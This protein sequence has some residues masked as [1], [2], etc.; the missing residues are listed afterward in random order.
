MCDHNK[1]S[2]SDDRQRQRHIDYGSRVQE[3]LSKADDG[4]HRHPGDTH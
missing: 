2:K 4:D 1:D 3:L